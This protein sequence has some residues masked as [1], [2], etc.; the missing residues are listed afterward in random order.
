MPLQLNKARTE[1]F[2]IAEGPCGGKSPALGELCLHKYRFDAIE[3][4]E[5]HDEVDPYAS[6]SCV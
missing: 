5:A 6:L 1:I 3:S 4:H 2:M